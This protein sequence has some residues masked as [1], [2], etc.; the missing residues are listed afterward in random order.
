MRLQKDM[1]QKV[2]AYIEYDY[3][4]Y[5]EEYE[6]LKKEAFKSIIEF[7]KANNIKTYD[8]GINS[9][10]NEI[11]LNADRPDTNIKF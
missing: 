10:T 11:I 2:K 3:K 4:G 9:K 5:T 6:K 7:A 8:I 1:I